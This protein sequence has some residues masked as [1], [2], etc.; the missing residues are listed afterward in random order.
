M[1]KAIVSL[2]CLFT[3]IVCHAQPQESLEHFISTSQPEYAL[4]N[5]GK[6]STGFSIY[7]PVNKAPTQN[8]KYEL[9][10]S[11]SKKYEEEESKIGAFYKYNVGF[12]FHTKLFITDYISAEVFTGL[13][14]MSINNDSLTEVVE[15]IGSKNRTEEAKVKEFLADKNYLLK[16]PV[17][18]SLQFHIAPFGGIR[19]YLTGGYQYD[20]HMVFH[21]KFS[22]STIGELFVGGGIDFVFKDDMSIGIEAQKTFSKII[23]Q[24]SESLTGKPQGA[25]K[26]SD[27]PS[28]TSEINTSSFL[29]ALNFSYKF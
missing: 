12:K 10:Q 7:F 22:V 18:L 15:T 26:S 8:L 28:A 1:R 23:V 25:L 13:G 19:P 14:G 24:Y 27:L 29:F 2:C 9:F 6:I 16:I 4:D 11:E 20:Y 17:G 3:T 5:H 21:D